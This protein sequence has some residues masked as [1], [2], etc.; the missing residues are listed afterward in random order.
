MTQGKNPPTD[1]SKIYYVYKHM[2]P[3]NGDL[4]YV[5]HGSKG[6]AWTHGSKH[7]VLRSQEHLK[8]LDAL[9]LAGYIP[10]DWVEVCKRGLTKSE[11]CHIEQ[12]MIREL[13]PIF[14]KPMGLNSLRFTEG[15]QKKA[16]TLRKQ[17][18]SYKDIGQKIGLS[19]MTV[20]RGL[21]NQTKNVEVAK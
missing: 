14:N 19:T 17:G 2:D 9:L 10:S 21:N 4:L 8:H 3:R 7:T 16:M 18:L 20:Y 15:K 1:Y 6:R 12:E 5:G 13:S 11:A